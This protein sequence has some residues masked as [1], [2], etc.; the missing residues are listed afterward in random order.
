MD[1]AISSLYRALCPYVTD[2]EVAQTTPPVVA[3]ASA[4]Q[5]ARA[6]LGA[7]S[8]T[9]AAPPSA[10]IDSTPS[11]QTTI[12]KQYITQPIVERI[13][14]SPPFAS[15]LVLGASTDWTSSQLADLQSQINSLKTQVFGVQSPGSYNVGFPASGGYT[16]NIAL[17]QRID[18]PTAAY[19]V[20]TSSSVASLFNGGLLSLAS[21]TIGSGTQTGGLTISGGATTT[22]TLMLTRPAGGVLWGLPSTGDADGTAWNFTLG[23]YGFSNGPAEQPTY[24]DMVV[25]YGFNILGPNVAVDA[26]KPAWWESWENKYYTGGQFKIERHWSI[27]PVGGSEKR[28]MS[29]VI[30]LVAGAAGSRLDFT[31]E[32]V[33]FFGFNDGVEKMAFRAGTGGGANILDFPTY[34]Y[35]RFAV[36][37]SI[38]GQ[39]QNAAGSAYLDLP[40]IDAGNVLH[41]KQPL[42][43]VGPRAD[44]GA[45]F[46]GTFA[47]FQMTSANSGDTLINIS[48]PAVTGS[49]SDYAAVASPT[50][51][52]VHSIQNN[53]TAATANAQVSINTYG[54]TGAGGDPFISFSVLGQAGWAAGIDNSDG[55]KFKI[56]SSTILG[57]NDRF[58][59]DGNGNVGIGTTSP[60]TF[61]LQVKGDIG[62]D[63]NN[64]YVLGSASLA[65]GC[66]YYNASVL[67]TCPS[68]QR[69][70]DNVADL[71]FG[72][73]PLSQVAGLRLGTFSYKSA[74]GSTYSGLV[75]QEV[76]TVAP[77]LVVT[78]ASTT[79]KAVKY[80]D[81]QW[82]LIA[83]VQQL[84]TKVNE[85]ADA[86]A[87][88]ADHFT[89]KELTFTR[90]TGDEIDVKRTI[91][92]TL[93]VRDTA[94]ATCISRTQL[95]A[96][97]QQA[98]QSP[99]AAPTVPAPASP[100]TDEQTTDATVIG[101]SAPPV[102]D[103][104]PLAP[105]EQQELE[106]GAP[107]VLDTAGSTE[108]AP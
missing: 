77:E 23:N 85:L 78:D 47:T 91:T 18:Q 93:C 105:E 13:I 40:Y 58:V 26:T 22:G 101:S 72:S 66:L 83:A 68:D 49:L 70:K 29:A 27:L 71:S 80:G 53:S 8:S 24:N 84:I 48:G 50:T 20:A 21:S 9:P 69:L 86:V 5:P 3:T 10:T 98:G 106:A 97:L 19:F 39:Q 90:A 92:D 76:E 95:D 31:V 38:I 16:N 94:G 59:I 107:T 6:A 32:T 87:A 65:W 96:L 103:S 67:G 56:L 82:L 73:D 52:L 43:V 44:T 108:P 41:A 99:A 54:Y 89:T 11:P 42:Y 46:P 75:A 14:Q 15:G 88:F 60:G 30:P 7:A 104:P 57:T 36:N 2:C 34:G 61:K 63:A 79:M 74:P 51:G 33:G 4:T 25:A 81:I 17:T 1:G 102:I 12:V 28:W 35:L 55:K 45:T 37:N 64:T 100:T 62:P